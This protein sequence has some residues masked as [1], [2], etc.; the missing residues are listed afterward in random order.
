MKAASSH[1]QSNQMPRPP[2]SQV[3]LGS[4]NENSKILSNCNKTDYLKYIIY[5]VTVCRAQGK[6][7]GKW[8][9]WENGEKQHKLFLLSSK[10]AIKSA[11]EAAKGTAASRIKMRER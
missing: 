3:I 5:K 6:G 11:P 2:R 7:H 10:Y 9:K 8:G 1:K 4:I